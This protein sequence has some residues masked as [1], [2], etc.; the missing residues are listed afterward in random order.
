M[1]KAK[2]KKR[3]TTRE[4]IKIVV[5][6]AGKEVKG[7]GGRGGKEGEEKEKSEVLEVPEVVVARGGGDQG[8]ECGRGRRRRGEGRAEE[9]A[10]VIFR[11]PSS[12]GTRGAAME[13]QEKVMQTGFFS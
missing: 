10:A 2:T 1:R 12:Q 6:V 7:G 13:G 5:V 9:R 3:R 8:R 11:F 4:I